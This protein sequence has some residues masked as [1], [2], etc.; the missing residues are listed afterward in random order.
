MGE[1]SSI[2]PVILISDELDEEDFKANKRRGN[3]IRMNLVYERQ[4]ALDNQHQNFAGQ[5][6]QHNTF[7][8]ES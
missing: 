3:I 8:V 4:P 5:T 2:Q 7:F 6:T 1:D